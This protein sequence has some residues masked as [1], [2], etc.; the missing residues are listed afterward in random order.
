MKVTIPLFLIV[1]FSM[2]ACTK[3]KL[4]VQASLP[5]E[6]APALQL[7]LDVFTDVDT[8]FIRDDPQVDYIIS[9]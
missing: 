6:N 7:K 3:P 1:V 4:P 2:I 9:G 8:A 5:T